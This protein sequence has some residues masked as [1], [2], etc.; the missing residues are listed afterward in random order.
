M[1]SARRIE[2]GDLQNGAWNFSRNS[3]DEKLQLRIY[4]DDS[5]PT[6]IYL[7][8]LHGDWTLIGGFRKQSPEKFASSN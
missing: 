6:L 1:C 3:M 7:P 8:G 5:L 4:G 2:R